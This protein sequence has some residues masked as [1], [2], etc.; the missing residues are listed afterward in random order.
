MTKQRIEEFIPLVQKGGFISIKTD[1]AGYFS[2]FISDLKSS[3]ELN[4]SFEILDETDD[5]KRNLIKFANSSDEGFSVSLIESE[6]EK[7]FRGQNKKIC[8]CLIKKYS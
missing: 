7:L 8:H 4:K 6:F 3:T 5:L 2:D 1:H